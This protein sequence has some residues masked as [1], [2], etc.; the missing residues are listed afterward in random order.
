M[1]RAAAVHRADASHE[2]K[3]PLTVMTQMRSCQSPEYDDE[4]KQRFIGSILTMSR[5]M[6]GR[7]ERMLELARWDSSENKGK[8]EV[9]TS[10]NW[11]RLMCFHLNRY[12]SRRG[13]N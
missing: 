5:Q 8:Y 9:R 6:R 12:S 1:E 2:R 7:I 11:F 13:W 3:P 4:K 10:A